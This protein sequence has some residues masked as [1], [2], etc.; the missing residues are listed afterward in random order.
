MASLKSIVL[1]KIIGELNKKGDA[2]PSFLA[3]LKRRAAKQLASSLVNHAELLKVYH[4]LV[5]NKTLARSARIEQLLQRRAVRTLSGV[6][7]VT[8]LTKPHPCPGHCL[9]CPNEKGLPKSYLKNE[10]A[11]HR[12]WLVK[13]DPFE[14]VRVRLKALKDNGHPIDK[15]ELIVLGGTWSAYPE[16]YQYWFIKECFRAVNCQALSAKRQSQ[17]DLKTVKKQLK[18]EQHKNETAKNRIVGLTLET[19]P[20]YINLN[21]IK[22]LRDLGCTRVELGVQS[23]FD[24]VLKKNQ[25]GHNVAAT[26]AATRLLKNA[27]FKI[28]Y[29]LMLNLPGS[30]PARDLAVFKKV[31]IDSDFQPDL[32]KIYPCA[33][34]R[35]A[36]L[37]QLWQ[38]GGYR[39]YSTKQ[40]VGL[41]LKIKRLIPPYVRIQRIIR[42]IPKQDIIAGN[43][44]SN[45]RQLI[46]NSGQKRC[47]CIRCREARRQSV[48]PSSLKLFRQD[49]PASAGQEIFLSYESPDKK[50]LYA[51]LRLRIPCLNYNA[52]RKGAWPPRG[53]TPRPP[54]KLSGDKEE[55][56]PVLR[57]A[58]LIRELHTYGQMVKIGQQ[59]K[60]KTQHSGLGKKLLAAAEKIVKQETSCKK[61]AV[62][63][64]VGA[65]EYYKKLDYKLKDEYMVK[66]INSRSKK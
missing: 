49:Y 56:L 13:F 61:I 31:F 18:Q 60:Q 63:S 46:D 41:L 21:E 24:D 22:K 40:L 37:Y 45:L 57:N 10:P 50:R 26:I 66:N 34:L 19:R 29:H 39:P 25:R 59:E 5:K 2:S 27:G 8:A 54:L 9:Y 32:L 48:N 55:L 64:G 65:R 14:Q 7:V 17:K 4:K 16:N 23:V 58:A 30:T 35:T 3:R 62:I 33:V 6:A 36:P 42:D 11:A 44:I 43:K 38:K 12:A 52:P 20:D 53:F 1:K 47:A 15:I 28:N 51:L